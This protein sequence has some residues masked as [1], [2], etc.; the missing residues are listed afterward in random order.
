M[1]RG[2]IDLDADFTPVLIVHE[3]QDAHEIRL[4]GAAAVRNR[5]DRSGPQRVGYFRS[6]YFVAGIRGGAQG[7]TIHDGFHGG[8]NHRPRM[9]SHGDG[10]TSISVDLRG[11]TRTLHGSQ[12]C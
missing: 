12:N 1:T 10:V 8:S 4:P 2:V 3:S 9:I 6:T 5:Q 11:Q 7:D